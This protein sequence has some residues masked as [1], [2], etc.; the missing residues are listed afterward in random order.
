M[1]MFA[2]ALAAFI[3][4]HV[5]LSATPLRGAAIR[6]MGE[7]PYRGLYSAASAILL[8]WMIFAFGAAR[9]SSENLQLWDP[10]TWGRHV[11]AL[12]LLFAFLLAVPGLITPA[13][14]MVGMEGGLAKPEPAKGM[15]R[16]TRHPFLWG[17]ALWGAGHL[18]ANGELTSLLLFGGLAAM[19]LIG[20]QSIDRKS[21]ARDPEG[22]ARFKA[23]T[24]NVPFAAIL[25]G[26]NRLA[27][28]EIVVPVLVAL[29]VF[30]AT[31]WFHRV[32]FGVA[33]FD[34]GA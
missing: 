32:F 24:S 9:A 34:F 10:P 31:L 2:A 18:M 15:T 7:W 23:V 26:R 17:V 29:V 8:I 12:L 28:G 27:V 16:I 14:T 25:Q 22:W 19:V 3:F 4:L 30:G 6:A 1:T 11:T 21:A 33:P 5:G 20:T 13:P